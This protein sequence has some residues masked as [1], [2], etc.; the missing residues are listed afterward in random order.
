M[1]GTW[2]PS[3]LPDPALP[4]PHSSPLPLLL[5]DFIF[6]QYCQQQGATE[7]TVKQLCL[8]RTSRPEDKETPE[9]GLEVVSSILL[10]L[11]TI[12]PK[13]AVRILTLNVLNTPC[14]S[15]VLDVYS[16]I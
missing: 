2:S 5:P 8:S 14:E 6:A 4:D 16:L 11:I 9:S 7:I 12:H 15:W 1:N 10:L 3:R 13:A